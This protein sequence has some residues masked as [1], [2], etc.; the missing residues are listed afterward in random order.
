MRFPSPLVR[1]TLL[2]RYKRFLFDARLEDGTVI[3]GSC[4]NTGS[5]MGL[6]ETGTTIWLSQSDSPTRKYRYIWELCEIDLGS[7]PK[8]VGINTSYPNTIVT[9]AVQAGRAK[10]WDEVPEPFASEVLATAAELGEQRR[11]QRA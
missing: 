11:R 10:R 5:L 6:K 2:Q 1:G 7:G 3:T 9:E 8:L 4:A